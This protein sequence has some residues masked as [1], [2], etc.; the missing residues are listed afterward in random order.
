MCSLDAV[1]DVTLDENFV[2]LSVT[3]SSLDP[4][5]RGSEYL[6]RAVLLTF[7]HCYLCCLVEPCMLLSNTFRSADDN[8]IVEPR[9]CKV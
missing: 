5:G 3:P 9:A 1:E 4:E 2:T 8:C 7:F 6:W